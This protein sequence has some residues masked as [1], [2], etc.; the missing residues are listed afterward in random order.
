MFVIIV[1]FMHTQFYL[2]GSIFI[3]LLIFQS[4]ALIKFIDVAHERLHRFFHAV[5]H[6]DFTQVFN[7]GNEDSNLR[8]LNIS[9]NEVMRKFKSIRQEGEERE[10]FMQTILQHIGTG[11]M[12]VDENEEIKMINPAARRMLNLNHPKVLNDITGSSAPFV[13]K[14]RERQTEPEFLLRLV[15]DKEVVQLALTISYCRIREKQ[16]RIVSIQDIGR[17]LDKKEIESWQLLTR[18]LA[19]EIMNSMTPIISLASSAADSIK[20]S[21]E[22]VSPDYDLIEVQTAIEAIG[23]RSEGLLGFVDTYRNLTRIPLP[24]Y[25]Q[26]QVARWLP[27]VTDLLKERIQKQKILF[28][29]TIEPGGIELI[30][31]PNLIEQV[32]INLLINAIDA[33]DGIKEPFVRIRVYEDDR[34]R[35]CIDIFNNGKEINP[36]IIEEIF[37]PFFT[38]K[39][40]GSGIGLSLCRQ[41]MHMHEASISVN[42]SASKGTTFTL[43]F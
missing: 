37:V 26:I 20:D 41:I 12:V 9:L 27:V 32:I 35:I 11:L 31:D 3:L 28:E 34:N 40:G 18:V 38:T 19:H 36:E 29:Y 25:S 30:A 24:N 2:T 23:R 5:S 22:K 10:F 42:S 7:L 13:K 16:I 1:I 17:E 6:A 8:E 43:K 33:V 4:W 14:I 39:K 15:H 21:I